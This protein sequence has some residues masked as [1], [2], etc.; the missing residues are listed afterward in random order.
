[1]DVADENGLCPIHYAAS[2]GHD[3]L[4]RLLIAEAEANM[5]CKDSF[6]STPLHLACLNGHIAC[7]QTLVVDYGVAVSVVDNKGR[8]PLHFATC[9]SGALE[10]LEMLLNGMDYG[11]I[12]AK[13]SDK[14]TFF[15]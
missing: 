14:G 10:C 15:P 8:T 9:F 12:N 5:E 4:L 2:N 7:M 3:K 6:G 11:L 1:M 13:D